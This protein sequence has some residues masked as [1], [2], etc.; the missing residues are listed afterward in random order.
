MSG[1]TSRLEASL[2]D[3]YRL[4]RELGQ[5]G[6]ATV[7]LAHDLKHDRQVAIKVLR[8]ELAAVIGA[9]RFLSEIKTTANLQHPHILPLFDSGA[10][11][12]F[13]FYVMPCVDGE[14]LRDRLTRDK[15]LPLAD[16]VRIAREVADALDYAHRKG[17]VHRDIKPE[18]I[19]LHDGRALVADF[20]IAL[21]ASRAGETRMTQTGMSLGTPAYMSPEQA[22][23]ERDIGPKSDIYALGAMTYEM[24]VGDPPFTGSTVQ[25][26][27]AKAMTEKPIPPTR[28]RDT[29]PPAVEHAVLTALQKLPADRFATAKEFADALL[30]PAAPHATVPLAA[31]RAPARRRS[32][33]VPTLATL[34]TL[35]LAAAAWSIAQP[36]RSRAPRVYDAGLADSVPVAF[37]AS[38]SATA[39]G[40][41]LRSVAIA[42]D[43]SFAVYA[44]R[45]GDATQ[46]WYR[47]LVDATTRPIA[48]TEGATAPRISPDGRRIAFLVAGGVSIV[49]VSGGESR[50][51]H[52]GEVSSMLEWTSP[53]TLVM[54][55]QDGYGLGWLDPD[56]GETHGRESARCL[57]GRWIPELRQLVCRVNGVATLLD[58]E[59]GRDVQV[60]LTAS[61]GTDGSPLA[62]SGFRVLGGDLMVYVSVDGELLAA[63][64]DHA[65]H[66]IG[67][68]ARLG[69]Q[70]RAEALGD[71]QYDVTPDGTLLFA[72]GVNAEIGQLVRLRP[73][74]TPT[75]LL[76]ERA[77]FQRFDLSRDGRW[78]AATVQTAERQELRIYDLRDG[79]RTVWL[80][81]DHVRHPLWSPAGDR[82][83]VGQLKGGRG[84]LIVGVPGSG[85]APDTLLTHDSIGYVRDPVGWVSEHDVLL[86]NWVAAVSFRT[87]PTVA[88]MRLD[89]LIAPSR[90]P[91]V[92]PGGRLVAFMGNRGGDLSV[93]T[94][95]VPG[96]RWLLDAN[97]VEPQWLAPGELVYRTG[98]TWN[99]AR[100]DPVTGELVGRP[101]QWAR[102]PRFSDTSG[103]SNRLQPDGSMVYLQGPAETRGAF[104]RVVPGWETQARA[105][106]AEANK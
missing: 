38:V 45:R 100:V 29:V 52:E 64:Y 22:M 8:P 39:Y 23:G 32:L 15:Q 80:S 96:R 101:T 53:S 97:G 87:D 7:Y 42:P 25:A 28:I 56:V 89:S 70:V 20:G 98:V 4:E 105:A 67:R 14:S 86:Q 34:T 37:A 69:H 77:A 44:A 84:S 12:A 6:M 93:T 26:I 103:W 83:M 71:A 16:A 5:G 3:R 58:P 49:P 74:G 99:V 81:A 1:V 102:D 91:A 41:A 63:P 35:S 92:S 66:R 106:V 59:T 18:N 88:P 57:F 55:D 17:I 95:P 31:P 13:L 43:G 75:P 46:L 19:L 30:Q 24:L 94:Y 62:G 90:F 54:T 78:L 27:V 104:L 65:R 60:R 11:E 85:R 76:D 82:L 68:P 79:Q 40:S 51:V 50:M 10:A 36:D 33:L 21:A 47:S 73:G 2:A 61:D 9:E 48:G 72:P